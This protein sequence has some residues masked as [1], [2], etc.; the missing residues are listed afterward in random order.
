[1]G[2]ENYTQCKFKV[3]VSTDAAADPASCST[4]AAFMSTLENSVL[5]IWKR[6]RHCYV[7]TKQ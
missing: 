4:L 1:M 6:I 2:H 3:Y 5:N 7:V